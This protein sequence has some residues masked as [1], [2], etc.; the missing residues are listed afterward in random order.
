MAF[1]LA[2]RIAG[3]D[4]AQAVQLAHGFDTTRFLRAA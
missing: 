3:A 2:G 4:V 1:A